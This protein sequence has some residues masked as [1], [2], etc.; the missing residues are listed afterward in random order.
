M[1][2]VNRML[3]GMGNVIMNAKPK[4]DHMLFYAAYFMY[5]AGLFI[6]ILPDT[7]SINSEGIKKGVKFIAVVLLMINSCYCYVKCGGFRYKKAIDRRSIFKKKVLM[8]LFLFVLMVALLSKD[9]YLLALILF[10]IS[11]RDL[12]M[13]ELFKMSFWILSFLT[14]LVLFLCLLGVLP[15]I[16]LVRST[17]YHYGRPRYSL[18]FA[19]S[20][21]LPDILVYL[22][23]YF[24]TSKKKMK[25]LDFVLFQCL[26]ILVYMFC[27]SR[28]GLIAL[29][30][31]LF[32]V[33]LWQLSCKIM[34]NKMGIFQKML[35]LISS[36]SF[37]SVTLLGLFLLWAYQKHMPFAITINFSII[38]SLTA[39]P[40]QHGT[41]AIS[42]IKDFFLSG[43]SRAAALRI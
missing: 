42:D 24:Y 8:G 6:D 35:R 31:L 21:Y 12:E 29:E 36:I 4:K 39:Y 23:A 40:Y 14:C 10:G 7:V 22:A 27:D 3:V 26:G 9:F 13:D 1:R 19:H 32:V 28:N 15:N 18:G 17:S 30:L 25:I 37:P 43:I 11:I 16:Q 33:L 20:L 38:Q 34:G 41:A 2:W 5:I